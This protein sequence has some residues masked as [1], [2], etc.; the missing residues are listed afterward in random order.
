MGSMWMAL[1]VFTNF[2]LNNDHPV[3]AAFKLDRG[4][5]KTEDKAAKDAAKAEKQA[6][7]VRSQQLCTHLRATMLT[8]LGYCRRRPRQEARRLR[9][10]S[11]TVKRTKRPDHLLR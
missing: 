3:V 9:T 5:L 2:A 4:E 1:G 11:Q 8:L 7:K 10:L 6:Q